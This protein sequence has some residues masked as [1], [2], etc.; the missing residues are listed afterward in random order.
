[1]FQSVWLPV[2]FKRVINDF[3][4]S[5][6]FGCLALVQ[7]MS[8]FLFHCI[9]VLAI[10]TVIIWLNTTR[11]RTHGKVSAYGY[12]RTEVK[13]LSALLNPVLMEGIILF[14][15][16]EVW[17]SFCVKLICMSVLKIIY[18]CHLHDLIPHCSCEMY[19][20]QDTTSVQP[21][22]PSASSA[23]IFAL[24]AFCA[25]AWNI[26]WCQNQEVIISLCSVVFLRND[27]W[28]FVTDNIN[29]WN[30]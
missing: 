21:L 26:C 8:V 25:T 11:I 22:T 9:T 27:L 13:I 6:H 20:L 14:F 19:H 1:M 28:K 17:G 3:W 29:V 7:A 23:Q 24:G 16:T 15:N 2:L 12:V 4:S 5:M 10:L 30:L 18:N